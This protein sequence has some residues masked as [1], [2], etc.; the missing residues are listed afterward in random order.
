MIKKIKYIIT[1]IVMIMMFN[2]SIPN[3]AYASS[4]TEWGTCD[5]PEANTVGCNMQK[6]IQSAI[7]THISN[8]QNSQTLTSKVMGAIPIVS[9][10]TSGTLSGTSALASTTVDLFNTSLLGGFITSISNTLYNFAKNE[11]STFSSDCYKVACYLFAIWLVLQSIYTVLGLNDAQ[12]LIMRI[13]KNA[14]Y[15]IAAVI[16]IGGSNTNAYWE[17]FIVIPLEISSSISAAINIDGTIGACSSASTSGSNPGDTLVEHIACMEGNVENIMKNG[18]VIGVALPFNQA[19]VATT[20]MTLVSDTMAIL[21]FLLISGFIIMMM[22]GLI[23]IYYAFFLVDVVLRLCIVSAFAPFFIGLSAVPASRKVAA[24]AF[25]ELLGAFVNLTVVSI[26]IGFEGNIMYNALNSKSAVVSTGEPF[27][28]Y[29]GGIYPLIFFPGFWEIILVGMSSIMLTRQ[30]H[31][32]FE[33]IFGVS[34]STFTADK[35]HQNAEKAAALAV[36]FGTMGGGKAIRVG[37]QV[38]DTAGKYAQDG[39]RSAGTSIART[40]QQFKNAGGMS[41]YL[42]MFSKGKG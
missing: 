41:E 22:F 8:S 16:L 40:H 19:T 27:Y 20:I 36:D 31:K 26:L 2:T 9:A 21:L 17:D 38:V 1:T 4:A 11:F 5:G 25:T 23:I 39:A 30:I 6:K 18:I 35:I 3:I 14:L 13:A 7:S 28:T 10:F 42:K 37:K 32:M 24:A 34:N 33:G 15:L 12:A 29:I